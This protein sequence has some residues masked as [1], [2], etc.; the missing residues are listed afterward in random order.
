MR[1]AGRECQTGKS[2][3]SDESRR[4]FL[5]S[6]GA[7][8]TVA[9]VGVSREALAKKVAFKL[10]KIEALRK[11]R[12]GAVLKI[13]GREILFIRDGETTIHALIPK[14]R[15]KACDVNYNA[16][17]HRIDCKCHGSRYTVAGKVLNGPAT[18]PLATLPAIIK[19]GRVIVTLD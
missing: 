11:P 12:G 2:E 9:A 13:K 1:C 6:L 10:A 17:D 18:E 14:C 4:K 7:L 15:H 5:K 16:K 8:A 3:M 19:K